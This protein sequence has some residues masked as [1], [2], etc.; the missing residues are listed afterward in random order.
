MLKELETRLKGE[1]DSLEEEFSKVGNQSIDVEMMRG[2]IEHLERVLGSI[3]QQREELKV[4]LQSRPRV[5]VLREA[6]ELEPV[7]G[8]Q[9]I[10]LPVFAGM[11][12]FAIPFGLIAVYDLSK[13]RV[14]SSSSLANRTG[15]EIVGTV[16]LVPPSV[17]RQLGKQSK[18]QSTSLEGPP[19][20]I[21]KANRSA[22]D[23]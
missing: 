19:R 17:L 23:L 4:E 20:R 12:T 9:R 16:P 8:L 14:N 7:G 2:E 5:E 18:T 11:V 15:L 22:F 3:A 13:R 6:T 21:G 10:T 1:E